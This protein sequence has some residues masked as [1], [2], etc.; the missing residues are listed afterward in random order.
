MGGAVECTFSDPFSAA[1]FNKTSVANKKKQCILTS[2]ADIIWNV[3]HVTVEK[4]NTKE[5]RDLNLQPL[6]MEEGGTGQC[7]LQQ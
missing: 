1:L 7:K 5:R 2:E 6:H 4:E 3:W